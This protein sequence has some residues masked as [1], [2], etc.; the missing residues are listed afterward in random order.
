[1]AMDIEWLQ[2]NVLDRNGNVSRKKKEK[3]LTNNHIIQ[4]QESLNYYTDDINSLVY[5]FVQGIHSPRCS[6]C[7][8]YVEVIKS[9]PRM[10]CCLS[11]LNNSDYM[12]NKVA[13]SAKANS[14]NKAK[15]S[16]INEKRKKTNRIKYGVDHILQIDGMA[17]KVKEKGNDKRIETLRKKSHDHF[18]RYG[19]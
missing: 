16:R 5:A 9:G 1:M 7:S 14:K 10:F 2:N 17:D 13:E 11:C 8:E 12:K 18:K 6:N 4:M 15:Q 3:N 19:C